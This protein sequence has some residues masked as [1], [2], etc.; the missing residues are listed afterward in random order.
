MSD[1]TLLSKVER[2]ARS[3]MDV[4]Q[5]FTALGARHPRQSI[6]VTLHRLRTQGRVDAA[7]FRASRG[8]AFTLPRSVVDMVVHEAKARGVAA[9]DLA[10]AVL[11]VVIE[12]DMVD[13][14][15]DGDPI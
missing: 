2:L 1:E 8:P 15:L 3:G 9:T 11:K 5:M 4:D 12:E 13:T 6:R 14:V 7:A 10:A